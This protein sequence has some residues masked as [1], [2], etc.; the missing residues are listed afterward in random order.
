MCI[1]SKSPVC[2]YISV[3]IF[4]VC[5]FRPVPPRCVSRRYVSSP[6]CISLMCVSPRFVSSRRAYHRCVCSPSIFLGVYLLFDVYFVGVHL[7]FMYVL[8][9]PCRCVSCHCVTS[10]YLLVESSSCAS[11]VLC[12]ANIQFNS[13]TDK[14]D[15]YDY[16]TKLLSSS[17]REMN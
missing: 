7:L 10:V 1:F 14:N 17:W 13:I 15:R 4:S 2:I 16:M 3:D 11:P 8:R 9:V 12:H 6:V 5:I